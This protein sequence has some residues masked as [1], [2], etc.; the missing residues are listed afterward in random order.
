MDPQREGA[1]EAF[2]STLLQRGKATRDPARLQ[3]MA[4]RQGDQ[5]ASPVAKVKVPGREA[6]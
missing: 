1:R 4:S 3:Q 5:N 6:R 2:S